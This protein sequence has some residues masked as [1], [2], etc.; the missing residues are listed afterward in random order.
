MCFFWFACVYMLGRG[1]PVAYPWGR[2]TDGAGALSRNAD[3][4]MLPTALQSLRK[5]TGWGLPEA[6]GLW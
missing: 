1:N 5:N 3:T 6:R 2:S 4:H